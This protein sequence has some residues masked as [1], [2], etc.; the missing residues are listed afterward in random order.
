LFRVL[1]K[2]LKTGLFS[3]IIATFI[4][5]SLPQLSPD[6]NAPT[7]ALLTQLVNISAETA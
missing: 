3:S 1:I 6:P 7:V 5:I 2:A 4:T